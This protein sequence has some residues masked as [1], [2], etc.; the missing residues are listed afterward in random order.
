M[1]ISLQHQT[2]ISVTIKTKANEYRTLDHAG[3]AGSIFYHARHNETDYTRRKD[4]RENESRSGKIPP[5]HKDTGFPGSTGRHWHH[6][7]LVDR[8]FTPAYP[9]CSR[10]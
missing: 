6:I 1:Y 3:P 7:P 9:A 10:L 5:S 2:T 4:E 8:L